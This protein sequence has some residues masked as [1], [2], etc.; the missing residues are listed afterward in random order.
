MYKL[1]YKINISGKAITQT[2]NASKNEV[3]I[4][5]AGKKLI[6][7]KELNSYYQINPTNKTLTII[8]SSKILEQLG[9]MRKLLDK[10]VASLTDELNEYKGYKARKFEFKN[11][12]AVFS[13]SAQIIAISIEGISETAYPFFQTFEAQTQLIEIP[14]MANEI[15]AYNKSEIATP[16]GIQV[17]EIE[18]ISVEACNC[19]EEINPILSYQTIN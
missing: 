15:M 1:T 12:N 18:L 14:F 9:T 8:D 13:I 3:L 17:Q 5:I 11:T 4:D 16:Q 2:I 10:T 7:L 6:F 19:S